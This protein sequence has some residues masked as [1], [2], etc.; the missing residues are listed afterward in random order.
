MCVA[1]V[2][3]WLIHA[4]SLVISP[5]VIDSFGVQVPQ[6]RSLAERGI[7]RTIRAGVVYNDLGGSSLNNNLRMIKNEQDLAGIA[8]K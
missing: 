5:C 7:P 4:N 8:P 2:L 1:H 3:A 6:T